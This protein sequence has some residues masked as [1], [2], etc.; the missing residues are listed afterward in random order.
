MIG[1]IQNEQPAAMR[2][3]P[4]LDGLYDDF[5]LLCIVFGQREKPCYLRIGSVECLFALGTCPQDSLV[6]G[7]FPTSMTP[8][9]R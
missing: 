1:V 7:P 6:V 3:Q 5:L 9:A 4:R 8:G 2:L